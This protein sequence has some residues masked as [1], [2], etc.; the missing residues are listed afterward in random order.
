MASG[1]K[2][3]APDITFPLTIQQGG[4]GLTTLTAGEILVGNG[5]GAV[6]PGAPGGI[7]TLDV[8]PTATGTGL[9]L[10]GNETAPLTPAIF[11]RDDTANAN[12]GT[13]VMA[14]AAGQGVTG[15][16]AGDIILR[17]DTNTLRFGTGITEALHIDQSQIV[18]LAHPLAVANGGSGTAT[19]GLVSGAGISITGSW[20][21]QTI[22]NSDDSYFASGIL[23]IGHGGTGSAT[24][25]LVAGANIVLSGS[26]PDETVALVASPNLTTL[27]VTPTATGTGLTLHGNETGPVTPAFFFRDDT[28]VKNL[29][30]FLMAQAAGQG[31]TGSAAGDIVLRADT[32]TLRFGT[33][34]T[35]ALAIDQSQ[36]LTI[37]KT[38]KS[39]NGVALVTPGLPSI[40]AKV[41]LTGLTA[42]IAYTT[43]F[44]PATAG[45]FRMTFH[46]FGTAGGV[47][48]T[49]FVA[50]EFVQNGH[51]FGHSSATLLILAGTS[52][53]ED[54]VSHFYSDGG[55][56]IQYELQTTG[57]F[58]ASADLHVRLEAL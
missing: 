10:H 16:A 11:F 3:Y 19:P 58:P 35:E 37:D 48:D 20:P 4:T 47:N 27:D 43:L 52:T 34:V 40:V 49:L 51:I 38:V 15:S 30:T 36:L 21:D 53:E 1:N 26:W 23:T 25:A 45:F 22:T 24:P 46:I 32:N 7:A 57:T 29:G 55:T 2:D 13:M 50:N 17:A 44:T 5:T 12:L 33:G 42:A 41:D 14:M 56:A 6:L 31:V 39:Y 54:F 28:A 18:T 9:T 8:T